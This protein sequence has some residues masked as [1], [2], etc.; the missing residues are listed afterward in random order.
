[1]LLI[2][3]MTILIILLPVTLKMEYLQENKN[4][5]KNIC[6]KSTHIQNIVF[7]MIKNVISNKFYMALDLWKK[8]NAQRKME[9]LLT[10]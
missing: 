7:N 6:C 4:H 8:V 5:F 1:M 10:L 9:L 3:Y 2:K